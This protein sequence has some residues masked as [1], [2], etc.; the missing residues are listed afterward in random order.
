M[1]KKC[2]YCGAVLPEE[3]SFCPHCA[4]NLN[5]RAEQKLPRRFSAKLRITALLFC[6]AAVIG[7]AVYLTTR[8]KTYEGMGEVIYSDSDGAYQL[9]T[10]IFME[11]FEPMAL[12]E[13]KAGWEEFYRFPSWLYINDRDTGA[14]ASAAFLE[15]TASIQ[16]H[17]E[18]PADLAEPIQYTEPEFMD[19]N[20]EAAMGSLVDFTRDSAGQS[21]AVWD[22]VMKNGDTIRLAMDLNIIA[23]AV[24]TYD[25]E[26]TDLSTSQ[27]LQAFLD[28]V[29]GEIDE[30]DSVTI[31][32]PP[33]T[34]TEPVVFPAHSFNLTGTEGADGQRTTFAS[35]LQIG[36]EGDYFISY[37][38]NLDFVGDGSGVALAAAGRAWA[39]NCRFS[40]W[41]TGMMAYGNA[42]SN[43]TDCV[44]E[45]CGTGLHMN[46]TDVSPSDSHFTGN[47]F[48]GCGTAVLLE[49]VP[50]EVEMDF[51]Q[52]VFENNDADIDNRCDQSLN[53]SEAEFQ[54]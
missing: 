1:E 39:Q 20:P 34:Y 15:K 24:Y 48:T 16:F 27:A 22:I 5:P 4:R 54:S 40:N 35:G 23:T 44:F 30:G 10:S 9:L 53:L 26:D 14:D 37:L 52:C 51:S 18:Q 47:T 12:F 50:S 49:N 45:N 33:V 7:A 8:P 43:T 42:W 31:T 28:K 6:L 32:L 19:I 46:I 36:P 11:R 29:A 13:T 25:S 17:V 38:K 3:S 41:K 2:P 21:Q